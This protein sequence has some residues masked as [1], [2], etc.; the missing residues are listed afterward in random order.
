MVF[1]WFSL[2]V[3]SNHMKG[4][5]TS[6]VGWARP[7]LLLLDPSKERCW[8]DGMKITISSEAKWNPVCCLLH[9]KLKDSLYASTVNRRKP[10]RT[11]NGAGA[12]LDWLSCGQGPALPCL[13]LRTLKDL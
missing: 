11:W 4:G 13:C 5:E 1:A 3:L 9:S 12:V 2:V 10:P 8:G 7:L 6:L